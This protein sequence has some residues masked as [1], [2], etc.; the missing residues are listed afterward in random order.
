[1]NNEQKN[2]KD[3]R[4]H[5]LMKRLL[6]GFTLFSFLFLLTN[7]T[8]EVEADTQDFSVFKRA[9]EVATTFGSDMAPSSDGAGGSTWLDNLLPGN[10]G[11]LLGYSRDLSDDEEGIVGW[12]TSQ[13][14]ANSMTYNYDQLKTLGGGDG[15]A[16]NS[17][18]AYGIYGAQLDAMGLTTTDDFGIGDKIVGY[19]FE[20]VYFLANVVPTVFK[21]MLNLLR[22]FN[23]FNLFFGVIEGLSDLEVP[24]IAPLAT[25]IGSIYSSIQTLSIFIVVPVLIGLSA[26]SIFMF[27]GSA[28]KKVLRLVVRVFMIFAGLP[29]IG[30][31][32][33][34]IVD[35]L[36]DGMT[37]GTNF[38]DYVVASQFVDT[39]GWVKSTR[40]APPTDNAIKIN[41]SETEE[42]SQN[43]HASREM[44]LEINARRV[45]GNTSLE[46][47]YSNEM[48]SSEDMIDSGS[49]SEAYTGNVAR[50]L[51]TRFR[52]G[53]RFSAA[54]FEG[55]IKSELNDDKDISAES[56][57][58]M[59][60]PET[61]DLKSDDYDNLFAV[62]DSGTPSEV[63]KDG[64]IGWSIY[65]MGGLVYNEKGSTFGL[66]GVS[67][68][69]GVN[70]S[71]AK[72]TTSKKTALGG[73]LN[74]GT[75]IGLSP[76]T[77][78]NFM[79]T[80]FG[81]L[82]MTTFSP[83]NS[84]S[85]WSSN[86]YASVSKVN[87]GFVGLINTT[88]SVVLLSASAVIG[89]AYAWALFKIVLASI[90]RILAGVFGT[91]MGSMAMIT[92]L[93]ISTIVLIIEIIGTLLLYS[94]FDTVFMSAVRSVDVLLP[95]VSST[96]GV[97]LAVVKGFVTIILGLAVMF[98]AL[99]NQKAFG[100][101]MEE[102]TTDAITKLM[103][104]LDNSLNQGN[105]LGGSNIQ[106]ASAQGKVLGDDGNVGTKGSGQYAA[107]VAGGGDPEAGSGFGVKD[108]IGETLGQEKLRALAA[109]AKGEEYTP[110]NKK[111]LAKEAMGRYGDSKKAVMGDKMAA[112][113][114]GAG[115]I[116]SM[117]TGGRFGEFDGNARE[118]YQEE[119]KHDRKMI[120]D[121][122]RGI[123]RGG[124]DLTPQFNQ[125][126]EDEPAND[127]AFEESVSVAEAQSVD[128]IGRDIDDMDVESAIVEGNG[129]EV[130]S[131]DVGPIG[132][133]S[134]S[135]ND[136]DSD[137]DTYIDEDGE[138]N[139]LTVAAFGDDADS[140]SIDDPKDHPEID[141]TSDAY[142]DYIENVGEAADA[143]HASA[144]QHAMK[145]ETEE[146]AMEKNLDDAAKIMSQSELSD[147][148]KAEVKAL[149][150]EAD[151]HGRKSEE[152][153]QKARDATRKAQKLNAK[154]ASAQ[155]K[156]AKSLSRPADNQSKGVKAAQAYAKADSQIQSLKRE[157]AEIDTQLS[158]LNASDNPDPAKVAELEKKSEG[159]DAKL[160][161]VQEAMPELEQNALNH[162]PSD[163]S[164][165]ESEMSPQERGAYKAARL[166]AAR[167][168]GRMAQ[169]GTGAMENQSPEVQA[170]RRYARAEN[171][172]QNLSKEKDKVDNKLSDLKA[173]PKPNKAKI[174]HMEQ[175]S[176]ELSE[177]LDSAQQ[178]LP[179]ME[180]KALDT[181]PDDPSVDESR[182]S[183]QEHEEHRA[184]QL[185]SVRDVGRKAERN[186]GGTTESIISK[187][188][189]YANKAGQRGFRKQLTQAKQQSIEAGDNAT[190]AFEAWKSAESNPKA[191]S[192]DKNVAKQ[193]YESAKQQS[194]SA[195]N[196][197]SRTK[198][199]QDVYEKAVNQAA[200]SNESHL[201]N[202]EDQAKNVRSHQSEVMNSRNKRDGKIASLNKSGRMNP[203][204]GHNPHNPDK[205]NQKRVRLQKMGIIGSTLKESR[206]NYDRTVEKL[207]QDHA[208]R[209]E[210][211]SKLTKRLNTANQEGNRYRS[212]QIQEKL[213]MAKESRDN[214]KRSL[215][216]KLHRLRK[217][218]PGLYV[219]KNG[220]SQYKPRTKAVSGFMQQ[221]QQGITGDIGVV[222]NIASELAPMQI[223]YEKLM[224]A[225]DKD[226]PIRQN[227]IRNLARMMNGKKKLLRNSGLDTRRLNNHT[228]VNQL[229]TG[230]RSEWDAVKDGDKHTS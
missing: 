77:M 153:K 23:P 167:D 117:M 177:Q 9:E 160:N 29:L 25:Y 13:F 83:E 174:A 192:H 165:N 112:S 166:E 38:G 185:A 155:K 53:Q 76:L 186:S 126:N 173:S 32:Y 176:N 131:D 89:L 74:S 212:R 43:P 104:G 42:L 207:K 7:Q 134:E 225:S 67:T 228:M 81:T 161:A 70:V 179:E 108:A 178:A 31:T 30:S 109:D 40:L 103:G 84:A 63:F 209:E 27:R 1:M 202:F 82:S 210:N 121:D 148:D 133:V 92:K 55:Y 115:A 152:H 140:V 19:L 200:S 15:L 46:A 10:A 4:N 138:A 226:T 8:M 211:V 158:E 94:V 204:R 50:D 229:V 62:S 230:L 97:I 137:S 227:Q 163:P 201:K 122:M 14:S 199:Q 48:I 128:D 193:R 107:A 34:A 194:K 54:D 11:G 132:T 214:S 106:G 91:A 20:L 113:L 114:G 52:S 205:L 41:D 164:V 59:F 203:S 171:K 196:Q 151:E 190:Q 56:I 6:L 127:K 85:S 45:R 135:I 72:A 215:D 216:A 61:S 47:L 51:L 36:A 142:N 219:N 224:Q 105:M 71:K 35:D 136:D 16:S 180:Q 222:V 3:R 147:D 87:S 78:Y 191:T 197:L 123:G 58:A 149:H 184:S 116:A 220:H 130:S 206:A 162:L 37:F 150:A 188:R 159:V 129:G 86:D 93:L 182:M 175:K 33:T 218:A 223:K 183:T 110:R 118:R 198:N 26:M 157:K 125:V 181:L 170:A 168:V 69:S 120:S 60:T 90:P 217:N 169:L 172:V 102:A 66:K 28:G 18:Y 101:M 5:S 88:E 99:K 124:D 221:G 154:Q 75:V 96:L 119:Q 100:K 95:S 12:V 145:A 98:F 73:D 21:I 139:A 24:I 213:S 39:E 80:E 65:N 187:Q 208:G 189:S 17:L 195:D 49:Q 57:T 79:N 64:D 144:E 44:V 111:D 22:I 68:P 141:P 146:Q 156:Q 2:K 143:Q